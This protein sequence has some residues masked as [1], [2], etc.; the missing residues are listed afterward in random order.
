M[1]AKS[2]LIEKR[3]RKNISFLF[4]SLFHIGGRK[5]IF[6]TGMGENIYFQSSVL[7]HYKTYS[8]TWHATTMVSYISCTP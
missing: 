6:E 4:G 7:H 2:V 8:A 3:V 1:N 5:N